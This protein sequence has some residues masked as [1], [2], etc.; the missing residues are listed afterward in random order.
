MVVRAILSL[1]VA[2]AGAF[3]FSA[4]GQD[5]SRD[6]LL[7]YALQVDID[8]EARAQFVASETELARG[9]LLTAVSRWRAMLDSAQPA[10]LVPYRGALMSTP[11]AIA[12]LI[13]QQPEAI[14]L[15]Y[16]R[17]T[18]PLANRA[19]AEAVGKEDIDALWRVVDRFP[20]TTAALEACEQIAS[21]TF[22]AG[23]FLAC[24]I[25]VD[26][27]LDASNDPRKAVERLPQMAAWRRLSLLALGETAVADSG[28]TEWAAILPNDLRTA[29]ARLEPVDAATVASAEPVSDVAEVLPSDDVLWS[30]TSS[31]E[32]HEPAWDRMMRDF[33]KLA[34]PLFMVGRPVVGDGFLLI[35]GA[36]ARRL[37]TA[38]GTTE[39]K[40]RSPTDPASAGHEAMDAFR[41]ALGESIS[42]RSMIDGDREFSVRPLESNRPRVVIADQID[43]S[44][45]ADG[46]RIE[47]IREFSDPAG[48]PPRAAKVLAPPRLGHGQLYTLTEAGG[49]LVLNSLDPETFVNRWGTR[50]GDAGLNL[51]AD[52]RRSWMP[53]Q[54]ETSGRSVRCATGNG[55]LASV[56]PRTGRLEWVHRSEREDWR[57]AGLPP[58]AGPMS[59]H[60]PRFRTWTGW[61]E[62]LLALMDDL[63]I[64]VG[65]ESEAITA[66]DR[67]TGEVRWQRPRENGLAVLQRHETLLVIR[68]D[69]VQR[70][71]PVD[72]AVIWSTPIIQPAGA[73][74]FAG[75]WY[76]QPLRSGGAAALRLEDGALTRSVAWDSE[77]A[78]QRPKTLDELRSLTWTPAGIVVRTPRGLALHRTVAAQRE[79]SPEKANTPQWLAA[80]GQLAAAEKL[81]REQTAPAGRWRHTFRLI[82]RETAAGEFHPIP[83]PIGRTP[84][85]PRFDDVDEALAAFL[86]DRR[87]ETALDLLEQI[88]LAGLSE[89]WVESNRRLSRRIRADL[90]VV[91]TLLPP[92]VP[93]S[94][95][96]TSV[97][98]AMRG[99][100]DELLNRV[101]AARP[102]EVERLLDLLR[103]TDWGAA[104]TLDRLQASPALDTRGRAR[105]R[106]ALLSLEGLGGDVGP[107]AAELERALRPVA[108]S[109]PAWPSKE[110]VLASVRS[111][112]I[113]VDQWPVWFEPQAPGELD[114]LSIAVKLTGHN[115]GIT[116][117]GVHFS[118]AGQ[119]RPWAIDLP[120]TERSLQSSDYRQSIGI[121]P[122]VLLQSGTGL[123]GLL[124]FNAAGERGASKLWDVPWIDAWGDV[125]TY[126]VSFLPRLSDSA[127]GRHPLDLDE[128]GRPLAQLGPVTASNLYYR[129]FGRLVCCETATGRRMWDRDAFDP[130]AFAVADHTALVVVSPSRKRIETLDPL[131]GS[132]LAT[133]ELGF[134]GGELRTTVGTTAILRSG[135]IAGTIADPAAGDEPSGLAAVELESG[136]LLWKAPIDPR[137]VEFKVGSR[138]IG[139]AGPDAIQLFRP[140]DGTEMARVAISP[141]GEIADVYAVDDPFALM[142][143][144]FGPPAV[145]QLRPPLMFLGNR[146][147]PYANG[148]VYGLDPHTFELKWSIP[149]EKSVFP[150][151]QPRDIPL[152]VINDAVL[153]GPELREDRIR[154]FDKRTGRQVGNDLQGELVGSTGLVVERS[155]SDG[156]V[157]VRTS[158]GIFRFEF[159]AAGP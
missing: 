3:P 147:R 95:G 105:Q 159:P 118:G 46:R 37:K 52:H 31:D 133:R 56:D 102:D 87:P 101:G 62:P 151:D 12:A 90:L 38:D 15:E 59:S 75:G 96:F 9:D 138:L 36:S 158:R 45:L 99:R 155:Q 120:K 128:F 145:E 64:W 1:I 29:V 143:C 86:L 134:S 54:I 72:G 114:R 30:S 85:P 113:A 61:R 119:D 111:W 26:R 115:R 48:G 76:V 100:L 88:S 149:L 112:N 73:G 34:Q 109:I 110:P 69:A 78:G 83:A 39:W 14:R 142:I 91:A 135:A 124:P 23:D 44:A 82:A 122:L 65:P 40:R 19:L 18:E 80:A 67:I 98:P 20:H 97:P 41:E 8:D 2:L 107:R 144:V 6:Q 92:A 74:A 81:L 103:R 89:R 28:W 21:R 126:S 156:W 127:P 84:A 51:V 10:G 130:D 50:L 66:L 60:S 13:D 16:V 53:A 5:E 25:A 47:A 94:Q 146:R 117:M 132:L 106:L 137:A 57:G 70:L 121:G 17:I 11:T 77:I 104:R 153:R 152:L 125:A 32:T 35:E 4:I 116:G 123:H 93:G 154:C 136:T 55:G 43:V 157:E 131:D 139:A 24:S 22:D 33:E 79:A 108:A 42:S 71:N 148:T 7:R 68:S 49:Q 63:V 58:V 27:W 129:E 150:L 140:S 141:P